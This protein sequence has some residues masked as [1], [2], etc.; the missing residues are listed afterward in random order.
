LT[1]GAYLRIGDPQSLWTEGSGSGQIDLLMDTIAEVS[2]A[3]TGRQDSIQGAVINGNSSLK[4]ALRDLKEFE[5]YEVYNPG[6]TTPV[7]ITNEMENL[8]VPL[9]IYR[10]QDF[11]IATK[12]TGSAVFPD[13]WISWLAFRDGPIDTE[14]IILWVRH[15][16]L[17]GEEFPSAEN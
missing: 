9:T 16:I 1:Q 15:D 17:S 13:D 11:V 5:F 3:E 4:W 2:V 10:G 12:A 6:I 7:L 8:Q 14:D